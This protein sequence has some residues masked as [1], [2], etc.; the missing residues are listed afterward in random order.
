MVAAIRQH[1]CP[2]I[3]MSK[4]TIACYTPVVEVPTL[5]VY[6]HVTRALYALD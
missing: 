5:Y 1:H 3:I 6:D 2:V 4:D